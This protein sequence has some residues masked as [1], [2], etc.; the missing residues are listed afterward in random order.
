MVWSCLL[1]GFHHNLNYQIRFQNLILTSLCPVLLDNISSTVWSCP[2]DGFHHNLN[3][4]IRFQNLILSSL[5][6]MLSH[7]ISSM[8][9]SCLLDVFHYNLNRRIRFRN[10]IYLHSAQYYQITY[11]LRFDHVHRMDFIIISTVRLDFKIFFTLPSVI[12]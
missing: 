12:R 2:L 11:L 7:N 6:P 5:Y 8:V 1:D 10:L 4:R 9:W 3:R